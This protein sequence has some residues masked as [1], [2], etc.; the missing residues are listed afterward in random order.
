[1]AKI[2]QAVQEGLLALLCYDDSP[3]GAKYVRSIVEPK[4]FDT[5]YRDLAEAASEYLNTYGKAPGEH[6][7]DLVETITARDPERGEVVEKIFR[8]MEQI[9]GSINPDYL[10]AQAERFARKQRLKKGLTKALEIFQS[11]ADDAV[12]QCEQTLIKSCKN[13]LEMFDPGINFADPSQAMSFMQEEFSGEFQTGIKEFDALDLGPERK[14]MHL[15]FAPSNRG[16]SW[17][18]VQLGKYG[19][20]RRKKVLHITLEMSE[21][22]VSKRY[23]QSLF[24]ISRRDVPQ[25]VT[26]FQRDDLGRFVGFDFTQLKDRPSLR[27]P[28]IAA[29]LE[30]RHASLKGR[31]P[32]IIKEFPTSALTMRG[33]E[34]YLDS[35]EGSMSFIPDLLLIDSPDLMDISVKNRREAMG[36][37]YRRVR[38]TAIDRNMALACVTQGNRESFDVKQLSEK[39][40]GED[41]SKYQTA[42]I[43]FSYSQ[44]EAEEKIGLAR[45]RSLKVRDEAKN[46]QLLIS[47]QYGLGQFCLDSV[48][49]SSNYDKK[50]KEETGHDTKEEKDEDDESDERPRRGVGKSFRRRE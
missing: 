43:V 49:M 40:M 45:I 17:W 23:F 14:T 5:Y 42:D 18:M 38:G 35:L 36:D 31:L 2:T 16:K 11:D 37:I 21:A 6:T 50:L 33:L 39:H 48:R 44:T 15:M 22:K 25:D 8:S 3:R 28:K 47:Q 46:M 1:M 19:L 10:L 27:D 30:E 9:K 29:Y 12:E 20:L 24:S 34:A 26:F 7:L 13:S 32:L 4:A 41:I